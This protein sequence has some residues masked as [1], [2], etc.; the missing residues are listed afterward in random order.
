MHSLS[1]VVLKLF[2]IGMTFSSAL[3]TVGD[4][5]EKRPS[6]QSGRAHMGK[7]SLYLSTV[8]VSETVPINRCKSSSM[9]RGPSVHLDVCCPAY[10]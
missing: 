8:G 5:R 1:E 10:Y 6:L 4:K 3:S 9:R 7:V 2:L